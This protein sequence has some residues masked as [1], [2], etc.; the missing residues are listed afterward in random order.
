MLAILNSWLDRDS[1]F[2]EPRLLGWPF[3]GPVHEIKNVAHCVAS[4]YRGR[5]AAASL[6]MAAREFPVFRTMVPSS[7][8]ESLSRRRK[9]R[10]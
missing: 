4:Y 2:S 9:T 5:V 3:I 8:A 7:G 10:T 6:V 1:R